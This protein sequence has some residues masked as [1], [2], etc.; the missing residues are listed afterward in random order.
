MIAHYRT[1]AILIPC[2]AYVNF[3]HFGMAFFTNSVV[4]LTLA[5]GL[6]MNEIPLMYCTCTL[7]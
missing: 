6:V 7:L 3:I 1:N 4:D 2:D 5:I